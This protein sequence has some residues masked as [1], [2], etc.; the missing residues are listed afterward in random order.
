[1][2]I[3]SILRSEWEYTG[4]E[5]RSPLEAIQA[6]RQRDRAICAPYAAAAAAGA[7]R[8]SA[9]AAA[10]Q[11]GEPAGHRLVQG[12]AACSTPCSSSARPSASAAWSRHRAATTALAL[13]YGAWRLGLPATVY[14]PERASADRVARIA[15]W[16]ARVIRH[17]AAWDDAHA[18]AQ[19]ARRRRGHGLYPSVRRR[20][21]ADGQG[22]LGLE[23][24]DD[25]PELDCVLIAIGGGG[26]IAGMAAAIKQRSPRRGSSASSRRARRRCATAVEAGRVAPLPEVRT[27]ADT[28]APRAVS[29]A[30]AGAG[31]AVRGRDRAGGATRR[32]SRRCAGCGPSATSWSSRPARR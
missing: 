31:T 1:M 10:A 32:W 27:I 28:L 13:A 12:R 21:H 18:Q 3:Y 26:L 6:A 16:G 25:V 17:G 24:L 2:K 19:R 9:G 20:A 22:T 30:N 29:R 14:L 5:L 7:A 4:H 15:A 23:L 8:R 11:A